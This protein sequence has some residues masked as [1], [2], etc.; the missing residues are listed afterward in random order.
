M[1]FADEVLTKSASEQAVDFDKVNECISS[2]H[3]GGQE[4]LRDSVTRSKDAGVKYSCTV[5][6]DDQVWC[7]RD[8]GT[9]KECSHGSSVDS[10]VQ[11][12]KEAGGT[13]PDAQ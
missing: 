11:H 1:F 5:R 7:I 6:V 4:L 8:S 13:L 12:I 9:W 10:L 3:G 2:D